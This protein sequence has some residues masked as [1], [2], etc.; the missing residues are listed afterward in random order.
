MRDHP[1]RRMWPLPPRVNAAIRDHRQAEVQ[2]DLDRWFI[3]WVVVIV[4]VFLLS[5]LMPV[6]T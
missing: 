3:T 4:A 5:V 1:Y 6:F 2:D